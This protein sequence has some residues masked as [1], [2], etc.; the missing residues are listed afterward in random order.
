MRKM[1]RAHCIHWLV[2]ACIIILSF[3]AHASCDT[4]LI[5][6]EVNT[7]CQGF[8]YASAFECKSDYRSLWE[9]RLQ[10]VVK[11]RKLALLELI[12]GPNDPLTVAMRT[13][14]NRL[15]DEEFERFLAVQ[16]YKKYKK[17]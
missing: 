5:D 16:K 6:E 12:K 17:D 13:I 9:A 3:G 11:Y 4:H 14:V 7:A 2:F 10:F 1:R 15:G 8:T